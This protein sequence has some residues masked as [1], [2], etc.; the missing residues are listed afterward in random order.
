MFD[1]IFKAKV[2]E[3]KSLFVATSNLYHN[4]EKGGFREQFVKS[5]LEAFLPFQFGVGSGIIVDR[6]GRQSP[7]VDIIV[8]DK[9]NMPPLLSRGDHGIY[10]LDSVLRVMEI[11][12]VVDSSS[13]RQF[14][15]LVSALHP[16][17]PA[18]LK[19]A[20][21]GNLPGGKGYYPLCGLF[22]FRTEIKDLKSAYRKSEILLDNPALLYVDGAGY[23]NCKTQKFEYYL[24]SDDGIKKFIGTFIARIGEAAKSRAEFKPADWFD[25]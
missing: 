3:L 19:L 5:L 4:G 17:N 18:G 14:S 16:D 21:P 22:G 10:P 12:S 2:R 11:K 24:D 25:S 6:W 7:Q 15:N 1:D 13:I 8:Y 9:M 23:Y 20:S